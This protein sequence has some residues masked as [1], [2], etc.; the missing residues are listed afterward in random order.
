MAFPFAEP[1][2]LRVGATNT[3]TTVQ[4]R[5]APRLIVQG[6]WK[7]NAAEAASRAMS[8]M[9]PNATPRTNNCSSGATLTPFRC[10]A[11]CSVRVIRL[12][13]GRSWYRLTTVRSSAGRIFD[14]RTCAREC[15]P[16][17][18]SYG[19]NRTGNA[20]KSQHQHAS[21]QR[22]DEDLHLFP[23]TAW[24]GCPGNGGARRDQAERQFPLWIR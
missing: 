21:H 20:R 9:R 5:L 13:I 7:L 11:F 14:W 24:A 6:E 8:T 10:G 16:K 15:L 12:A 1:Y 22:A 17:E 2:L 19:R 4:S 23:G 3:V 18:S